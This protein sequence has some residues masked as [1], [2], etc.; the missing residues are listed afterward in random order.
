MVS[1]WFAEASTAVV[2]SVVSL[3]SSMPSGRGFGSGRCR[4]L[5]FSFFFERRSD[6]ACLAADFDLVSLPLV[7]SVV[8]VLVLLS[9]T[10]V[11]RGVSAE[12]L[13]TS[14]LLR[15]DMMIVGWVKRLQGR[16]S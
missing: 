8:L 3:S 5:G 15:F 12:S 1:S 16:L 9:R 13:S 11:F 14:D 6:L 10:R 7:F 4:R 2:C